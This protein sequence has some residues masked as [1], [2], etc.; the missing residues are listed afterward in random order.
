MTH[1][2]LN[3][4]GLGDVSKALQGLHQQLLQFQAD[5]VGFTGS[6]L[7]LF[8]RATK[9]PSFAWLKP[10]REAI[11]ALD[12]RRAGDE[13]L[14]EVEVRAFDTEFRAFLDEESGPFRDRLNIA[15]QFNPEAIWA[16]G[17]ARKSLGALRVA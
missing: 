8:E 2:A 4:A 9:D 6:P 7:E 15:F 1:H 14:T 17:A 5:Q 12:E 3:A 13:P 16:V 10:L 11:V